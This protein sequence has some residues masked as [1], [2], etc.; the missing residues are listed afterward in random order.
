MIANLH[1]FPERSRVGSATAR[2]IGVEVS[3]RHEEE[4]L[5]TAGGVRNVADF[6]TAGDDDTSSCSPA[7]RS[8]TST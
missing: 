2:R 7:T 1:W 4:L 6:L 8:P 3:Y 5:G